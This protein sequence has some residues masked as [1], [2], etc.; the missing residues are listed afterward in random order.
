MI[1]LLDW[2]GPLLVIAVIT[3]LFLYRSYV[4]AEADRKR[5]KG[6]VRASA[7][8]IQVGHSRSSEKYGDIVVD[9]VLEITPPKGTPYQLNVRWRVKP[10]SASK[11]QVGSSLAIKIDANNPQSIYSAEKGIQDM[12]H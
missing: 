12:N 11:V 6:A 8:I 10:A 5:R 1:G 2:V 4:V 9:M 3:G 7:Q